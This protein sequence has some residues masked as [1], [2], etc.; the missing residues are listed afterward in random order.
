MDLTAVKLKNE[1]IN[2][3]HEDYTVH[4]GTHRILTVTTRC[5]YTATKWI[6]EV[7]KFY[8]N[9]SGPLLVGLHPSTNTLNPTYYRENT[10]TNPKKIPYDLLTLC[11]GSNCL[12]YHLPNPYDYNTPN[13]FLDFF[14]NPNVIVVG[15]NMSSF[16]KKLDEIHEIKIT[17][18]MDLNEMAER[19][20]VGGK[21]EY[22]GLGG[23]SLD[24]LAEV[25]CGGDVWVDRPEGEVEWYVDDG[26]RWFYCGGD[27]AE[28]TC[29]KVKYATLDAYFCYMVGDELLR[30]M[31]ESASSASSS[32]KKEKKKNKK[33]SEKS[34][35]KK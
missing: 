13:A 21:K 25:V 27:G 28:L 11:I 1:D 2:Y 9:K 20:M 12:L 32:S 18:K 14:A 3:S 4:V 31:R 19:V 6:T 24:R 30:K 17:H 34:D 22:P 8:R 16:A 23:C 7:Q 29:E 5:Y 15:V 35:K 10:T 26:R 33:K